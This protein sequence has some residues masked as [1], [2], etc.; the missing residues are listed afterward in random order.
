V[1]CFFAFADEDGTRRHFSA[2]ID[3]A[4][5]IPDAYFPSVLGWDVLQHFAMRFDWSQRLVELA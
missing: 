5:P 1:P 2:E 3:I 4:Q